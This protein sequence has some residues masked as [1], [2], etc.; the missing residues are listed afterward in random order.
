M[1][2]LLD[3]EA[4]DVVPLRFSLG[5]VAE[6]RVYPHMY[7]FNAANA[8]DGRRGI[9]VLK[10]ATSYS[11]FCQSLVNADRPKAQIRPVLPCESYAPIAYNF[12]YTAVDD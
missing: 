11:W 1:F 6:G 3:R 10:E 2:C 7:D 8:V 4:D 5:T 9:Y 12:A